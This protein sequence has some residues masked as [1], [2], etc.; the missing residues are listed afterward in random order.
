[1]AYFISYYLQSFLQ[2]FSQKST[3]TNASLSL[4]IG[5]S[6]WLRCNASG[7]EVHGGVHYNLTFGVESYRSPWEREDRGVSHSRGI[8]LREN[9][10]LDNSW[11]N[12]RPYPP[13]PMALSRNPHWVYKGQK[14]NAFFIQ[15]A[16]LP[17][18]FTGYIVLWKS[19]KWSRWRLYFPIYECSL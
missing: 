14:Q 15:N 19:A 17:V 12:N 10:P 11:M 5:R 4:F 6:P 18:K 13:F 1:M 2:S 3:F 9:S 8:S 16:Y 7:I